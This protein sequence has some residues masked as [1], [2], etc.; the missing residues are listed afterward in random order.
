LNWKHLKNL[1]WVMV[2]RRAAPAFRQQFDD[3]QKEHQLSARIVQESDRLPA[4]LTM[5]AT[6]GGATLVPSAIG[7]LRVP[8]IMFRKPPSPEIRI[9]HAFAYRLQNRSKAL[10]DFISLLRK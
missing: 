9:Q 1:G 8:G 6:G 4:V 5:V 10:K 7:R 3:L 2:S